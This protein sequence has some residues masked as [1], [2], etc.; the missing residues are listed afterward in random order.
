MIVFYLN[1][2]RKSFYMLS[3]YFSLIEK[4]P[5]KEFSIVYSNKNSKFSLKYLNNLKLAFINLNF[6][7]I[8]EFLINQNSSVELF[9][10]DL[11]FYSQAD[12]ERISRIKILKKILILNN[13][14]GI[15][16]QE[17]SSINLKP[18]KYLVWNH[19]F[20]SHLITLL[21]LNLF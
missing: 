15:S 3:L 14:I 7:S 2:I 4:E 6:V 18:E 8:E 11:D 21:H 17:I 12:I 1:D 16:I 10:Y 5:I 20:I 9:F 13:N 19:E